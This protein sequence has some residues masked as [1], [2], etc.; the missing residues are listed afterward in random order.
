MVLHLESASFCQFVV[1]VFLPHH[2]SK[3]FPS[4]IS[5]NSDTFAAHRN[6]PFTSILSINPKSPISPLPHHISRLN[7]PKVSV[8]SLD[9]IRSDNLIP[10]MPNREDFDCILSF[11][12]A[13]I[14]PSFYI[15]TL[16]NFIPS[17]IP[18]QF[19]N[20]LKLPYISQ[21][22]IYQRFQSNNKII[23]FI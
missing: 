10:E 15:E 17:F 8:H 2:I 13:K 23:F 1:H 3:K 22:L 16:E 19:I 18:K 11:L 20:Y 12:C 14:A 9:I 4:P 6:A 21:T 7:I 5:S